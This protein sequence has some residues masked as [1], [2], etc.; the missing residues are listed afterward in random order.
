MVD[1]LRSKQ[2]DKRQFAIKSLQVIGKPQDMRILLALIKILEDKHQEEETRIL[3]AQA[4]LHIDADDVGVRSAIRGVILSGESETDSLIESS[5]RTFKV[6]TGT[7]TTSTCRTF[8]VSVTGTSFQLLSSRL[9]LVLAGFCDVAVPLEQDSKSLA[10]N[11]TML[12]DGAVDLEFQKDVLGEASKEEGREKH[13]AR[14]SKTVMLVPRSL[15][16]MG[17]AADGRLHIVRTL[18]GVQPT[19]QL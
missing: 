3:A 11:S 13:T 16:K 1:L 18:P 17:R 5:R 15:S 19:I 2:C 8:P 6:A 4:L 14:L 10:R 9:A 12:V 7:E